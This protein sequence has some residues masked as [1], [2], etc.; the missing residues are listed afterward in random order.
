MG[1]GFAETKTCFKV[2][3]GSIPKSFFSHRSLLST[4]ININIGNR[5]WIFPTKEQLFHKKSFILL[6]Q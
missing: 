4:D 2:E 1:K 5:E 6:R 3:G